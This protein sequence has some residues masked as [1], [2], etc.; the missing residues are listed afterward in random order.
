[1]KIRRVFLAATVAIVLSACG[2]SGGGT[3]YD[4][5]PYDTEYEYVEPYVEPDYEPDIEDYC[6][7]NPDDE[8]CW[9]D[10]YI[11]EEYYDE[12]Y[13]EEDY[14]YEDDSYYGY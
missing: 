4:G 10:D 14:Y 9:N 11:P 6:S 8:V 13:Y 1:L 12:Y 3:Y 7:S 2:G 5:E